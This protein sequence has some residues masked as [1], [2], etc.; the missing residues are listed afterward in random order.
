[1]IL[2]N[3]ALILIKKIDSS[4]LKSVFIEDSYMHSYVKNTGTQPCFV[5]RPQN[6]EN[7]RSFERM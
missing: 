6:F 3:D 1:M 2:E 7:C 5:G 4:K